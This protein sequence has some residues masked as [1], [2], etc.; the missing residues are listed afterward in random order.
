ML[1]ACIKVWTESGDKIFINICHSKEIC[2]PEDISDEEFYKNC[3]GDDASGFVIPMA[4]GIEK[5]AK[6]KSLFISFN[7]SLFLNE[8]EF[9][10]DSNWFFSY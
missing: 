6:D 2:A 4:L 7:Y 5:M 3:M 10:Y 8:F 1:G 9:Q